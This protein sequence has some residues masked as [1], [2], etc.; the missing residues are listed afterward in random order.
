M[1]KVSG[2]GWG[3]GPRGEWG[4]TEGLEGGRDC[5]GERGVDCGLDRGVGEGQ[6]WSRWRGVTVRGYRTEGPLNNWRYCSP[7]LGG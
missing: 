6:D 4:A 7:G 3:R 2:R 1:G 5:H